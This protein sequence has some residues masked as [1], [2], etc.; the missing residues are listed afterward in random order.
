MTLALP[1]AL[2]LIF[3][4]PPAPPPPIDWS[5]IPSSWVSVLTPAQKDAL[6][7]VL[8]DEFCYCGC[9]RTPC[10]GA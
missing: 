3:S 5:R 9:P 8:A 6:A 10:S 4:A 1:L 2:S 7:R